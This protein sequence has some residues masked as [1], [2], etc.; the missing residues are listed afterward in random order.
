MRHS[1]WTRLAQHTDLEPA[2]HNRAHKEHHLRKEDKKRRKKKGAQS[3]DFS[4]VYVTPHNSFWSVLDHTMHGK[5]F[6]SQEGK[7]PKRLPLTRGCYTYCRRRMV[8]PSPPAPPLQPPFSSCRSCH[9]DSKQHI[10][11]HRQHYTLSM[12]IKKLQ[13]HGLS[14]SFTTGFFLELFF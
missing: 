2:E 1:G 4:R 3:R 5:R 9:F 13:S 11:P 12:K 10:S 7:K 6:V 8:C 14:S